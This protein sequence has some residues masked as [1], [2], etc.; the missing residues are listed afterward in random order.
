MQIVLI[1]RLFFPLIYLSFFMISPLT[2]SASESAFEQT[3]E[4][5]IEVKT[6]PASTVLVKRSQVPYFESNNLFM[7]LFWYITTR[8][9]AM[10]TPVEVG[11]QPGEM[12][13]Y[14]GSDAA[15]RSLKS[16]G[17]VS[18]EQL[19]LRT[20]ASI[21]YQGAYSERNFQRAKT[22]LED[23]IAQ[24]D[25]YQACGEA[26]AIYWDSPSVPDAKKHAEVHISLQSLN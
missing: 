6:I 11:I 17:S 14:V 15:Q 2:A 25:E 21:A 19:P 5:V 26:R 10:T 18:V 8:R 12:Y 16:S 13:F 9:I 1:S 4:G 20:V 22:K 7:P 24:Q 3:P 23:W